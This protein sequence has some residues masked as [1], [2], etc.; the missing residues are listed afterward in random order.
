MPC[1]SLRLAVVGH[2]SLFLKFGSFTK[3]D[4][5]LLLLWQAISITG[6]LEMGLFSKDFHNIATGPFPIFLR[7]I[8]LSAP[9]CFLTQIGLWD[10]LQFIIHSCIADFIVDLI[11]GD[12]KHR[13]SDEQRIGKDQVTTK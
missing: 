2:S 12:Y 3:L 8:L 1:E 10:L 13:I 9:A 4:L 6:Q 7:S 5:D 11:F